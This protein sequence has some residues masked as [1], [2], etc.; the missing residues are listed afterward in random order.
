[1][2][3]R[4]NIFFSRVFDDHAQGVLDNATLALIK[5]HQ[6]SEHAQSRRVAG[7]LALWPQEVVR[8]TEPRAVGCLPVRYIGGPERL[9]C[10]PKESG[11]R[12]DDDGVTIPMIGGIRLHL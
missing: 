9:P 10:F 12:L 8:Q 7:S 2:G 6:P 1:M 4:I 5:P 11:S 3:R